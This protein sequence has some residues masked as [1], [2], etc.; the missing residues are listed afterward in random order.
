[1]TNCTDDDNN[2]N[3]NKKKNA[4]YSF[5]V[6]VTLAAYINLISD[7]QVVINIDVT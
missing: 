4:A 2:N 6:I 7:L 1:M 3:N 5:V